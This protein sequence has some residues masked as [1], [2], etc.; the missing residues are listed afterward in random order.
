MRSPWVRLVACLL[1]V[2]SA[3]AAPVAGAS[4]AVETGA[5]GTADAGSAST[6]GALEETSAASAAPAGTT[7]ESNRLDR[8]YEV[9]LAANHSGEVRVRLRYRIPDGVT[10]LTTTLPV[11]TTVESTEGFTRSD[12]RTYEWTRTTD[13]PA[14]TYRLPVNET[15][16][17]GIEGEQ[18]GGYIYVATG[19]WAILRAPGSRLEISGTGSRPEVNTTYGVDGEGATGGGMVYVGPHRTTTREAGGQRVDLVVPEAAEMASSPE[20]VLDSLGHAAR[21]LEIGPR[22]DRVVAIVAPTTVEWGSAGLQRGE[23]DFWVRDDRGVDTPA[24]V[25]LHEYVH[26][27]QPYRTETKTRWTTEGMADYYA[28]LLSYRQG[29][30]SYERFREHVERGQK[31]RYDNVYMVGPNSWEGTLAAYD[32]GALVFAAL[33]RKIRLE[34]DRSATLAAA[35]RQ[36]NRPDETVSHGEFL[37]AVEDA[38]GNDAR[39]FART[40]TETTS[41]PDTWS[42]AAHLRA[43]EG[44]SFASEFAPGYERTGPYRN[45]MAGAGP[46]VVTGETLALRIAVENTGESAGEYRVTVRANGDPVAN[47]SATLEAGARETFTVRRTFDEPGEVVVTAGGVSETVTVRRP[48]EVRVSSLDVPQRAAVGESVE[49]TATV[50]SLASRPAD[51]TVALRA[52]DRTVA[53]RRFRLDV[54]ETA[55]LSGTVTFEEPGEYSVTAGERSRTIRVVAGS[56]DEST[57]SGTATQDGAASSPPSSVERETGTASATAPVGESG[58]GFGALAALVAL[59]ALGTLGAGSRSR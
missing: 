42:R 15:V 43:F 13:E 44:V 28:A 25:W 22:D 14:I 36:F 57:A 32:K 5:S 39:E 19:S 3:V 38:G 46:T 59:L 58:A 29:R 27:R 26:T 8:R 49:V 53:E 12:D 20:A 9:S 23:S 41:A 18:T 47:R 21:T 10:R 40:Y 48:G 6:V 1:L 35:V 24:N 11:N 4:T 50:G 55:T 31:T 45:D 54:D 16:S 37:S 2:A 30:I 33:D 34:S 51:G 52:D 7:R 56:P 17:R